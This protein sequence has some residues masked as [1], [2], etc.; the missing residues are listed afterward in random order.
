M[1]FDEAAMR[2]NDGKGHEAARRTKKDIKAHTL[3]D[4]I[5]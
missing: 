1:D 4:I 3:A 5:H 2:A